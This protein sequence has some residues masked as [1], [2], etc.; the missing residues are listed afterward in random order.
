VGRCG[1]H[2][3][4]SR[5]R[6]RVRATPLSEVVWASAGANSP[7]A[8]L[9]VSP[10]RGRDL[11][12]SGR[13]SCAGPGILLAVGALL[14]LDRPPVG[15]VPARRARLG[16]RLAREWTDDVEPAAWVAD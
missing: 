14:K 8:L 16:C 1:S 10:R 7:A 5:A 15:V 13:T 3:L 12:V 11:G 2:G 6:A 9:D 4:P